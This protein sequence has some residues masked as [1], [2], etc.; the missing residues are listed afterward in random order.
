MDRWM[1]GWMNELMSGWWT[2]GGWTDV[3][4]EG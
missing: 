4:M 3:W 1:D 2:F